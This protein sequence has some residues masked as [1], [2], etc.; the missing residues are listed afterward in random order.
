MLGA[1]FEEV[2]AEENADNTEELAAENRG[3]EAASST[4]SL[5][6]RQAYNFVNG[7]GSTV[8]KWFELSIYTLIFIT[9][10]VGVW[11]TVPGQE[12][13][14]HQVE[15]FAVVVFTIEYLIRLVGV[16]AD[17]DFAKSGN[18]IM[19][20]LRFMI[21]FYS[22]IDLFAIVPFYIAY[23][24]PTSF[25]ND[26][27]EYLRMLRIIRLVKLDK[28][29]PSITLIDDVIRLKFNALKVAV[30][31]AVSLWILFAA[32]MFLFE[33]KDSENDIDP[34][35][36]YGCYSDCTMTDRFQNYFDSLVYTGIHLTGDYPIT[37]YSWP[38]RFVCFFMVIAAVG[39]VSIPSGLIASGFV[40]I[41][42]SRNKTLQG[43]APLGRAGDDWYD[44]KYRQLEGSEPPPSRFGPAV[45]RWQL[46]VNSFLNGTKDT[47][48]RTQ[49]TTFSYFGRVFIFTI[50]ISNVIAVLLESIP[51]IDMAVGNQPG[52][53]FD[54]FEEFSVMI[55]ATEYGLRLFCARKNRE[56]LFSPFIYATTFFGIVDLLSTAP[57]FVQ[58]FLI[59]IGALDESGDDAKIFRIFRIFRILQ[60]EDFVTAFS[61]LDNV[62]RASKDVF[63]ATALVAIIIWVGCGALFFI[64]EENNPNWRQCDDI[65][66]HSNHP[67]KPGCYDFPSTAACNDFYPGQCSQHAFTSMPNSLYYTAVFL[68]GEW[69]VVDFSW[70]GR[71]VC[72]FL[73]VVGIALY[74]IPVGTLFD[75]FGAVLGLG[76]D[77]EEE[78]A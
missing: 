70:P 32:L 21:S 67:K 72:L 40:E 44:I 14:F 22:I 56:A 28:Y 17:P 25:V 52:N 63:K 69:G 38:A 65:P 60:L 41:V 29:V 48:G 39:V 58:Q 15:W 10:A 53:F 62:F 34:V 61:K 3:P 75:S 31:A 16:G 42:Q 49:W 55:F 6:E 66:L 26:Y 5:W 24:M 13:T 64:F 7:A 74:A 18:A 57:W 46:A 37:T 9:V 59:S 30:Y 2:V 78:E 12:N 8:A 36:K 50:I 43:E 71:F 4:G 45:D 20:R 73:C 1:G 77:D 33:N 35:P 11:Q 27:D 54:V 76:G 51:N 68:G 23:A 19:C 47:D